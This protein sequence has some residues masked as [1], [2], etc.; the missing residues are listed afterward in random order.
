MP[1]TKS[2]SVFSARSVAPPR[3]LVCLLTLASLAFAA[4]GSFADHAA[5]KAIGS[6][7]ASSSTLAPIKNVVL[8]PAQA[9][10]DG[11]YAFQTLAAVGQATDGSQRDLTEGATFSSSN[12]GVIRMD[13][14]G[15]AYPV[16]DGTAEVTVN[17]G[18]HT[19]KCKLTVKNSKTDANLGLKPRLRPFWSRT[20]ARAARVTALRTDRVA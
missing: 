3:S 12:P 4:G 14:D 18:G 8:E 6:S 19:A 7:S 17:V 16:S 15:V 5:R 20:A 1:V 10:L 13:K 2:S 9:T 11:S